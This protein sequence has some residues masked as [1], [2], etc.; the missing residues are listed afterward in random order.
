MKRQLLKLPA[1]F[2]II[3]GLVIFAIGKP[4]ATETDRHTI[5]TLPPQVADRTDNLNDR[6]WLYLPK[7]YKQASKEKPMPLIIYLHGSSRRGRDVAEVKANGLAPLMDKRDDFEFVVVSP[8]ALSKHPW[9]TCWQPDDLIILLVHLLTNYHLDPT[10]VYLT[11]LSMGGYGT[12]AA[13]EKHADHFA[14]AAPICGG[15]DPATAKGIG[16][17]PVWAFHGDD[18]RVVSVE[19]SQ[20]MVDAIKAA[21][22]N[23]KLTIYPGVGHDSYTRTYA[24]PKLYE[25]FLKHKRP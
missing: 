24:N 12:W 7:R 11:G 16:K 2:A 25:W 20:E 13:I 22:G 5:R 19:R 14:A 3:A 9:Q 6:F 23:A 17:L 1:L 8:Q 15:G 18:D 10:R 4:E 21:K